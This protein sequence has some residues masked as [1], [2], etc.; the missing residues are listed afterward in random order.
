MERLRQFSEQCVL[1]TGG[2]RGIGR[3]IALAFAP[4]RLRIVIHYGQQYESACH[5]AEAC[6]ALGADVRLIQA[7]LRSPQAIERM[8]DA[9]QAWGWM[10]DI[11]VNNAA[12]SHYAPFQETTLAVWEDVLHV[13]LRAPYLCIQAFAPQ[14]ISHKYGRIINMGSVWGCVGAS[15]EAV[16]ATAKGGLHALTKSLAKEFAPSGIT[17][18]AVAPG[19]ID[20]GMMDTFSPEEKE[21]LCAQIP[22]GRLGTMQEVSGV[23]V[24][25]AQPESQYVTGQIVCPSGGWHV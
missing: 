18:N 5:T 14:M 23:V 15:C 13:N 19:A 16:Y 3:A 9:V 2:S 4:Y 8:R 21:Q 7:D 25:L 22:M 11:L 24:H 20:G 12:V 1:I 17:V 10:P 6:T